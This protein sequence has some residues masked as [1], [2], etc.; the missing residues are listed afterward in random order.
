MKS[1]INPLARCLPFGSASWSNLEVK[2]QKYGTG[3]QSIYLSH[4]ESIGNSFLGS[5]LTSH[6][7]LH[8]RRVVNPR[9]MA[10]V[11]MCSTSRKSK[12]F[13]LVGSHRDFC[14][15]GTRYSTLLSSTTEKISSSGIST[16]KREAKTIFDFLVEKLLIALKEWKQL[17]IMTVAGLLACAF[18]V[19]PSADAVDALKTCACLLKECRVELA[20]CIGNPLCAAN[21][22]CL[23]TCNNRPDETECQIKCGDLLENSVV[24]EFNECAVS[25]KKCVPTK[26]DIGE[27]PVPD[28]AVLVKSFNISD[29]S[30]K[31]FITSGLNPTFDTFNCQQHVFHIESNQLV[32]N[33]SWRIQTP[34]GGFFT[35]SAIQRFVQDPNQPGI[36]YNHD[37]EYLHYQDDWY[38]LSSKIENKQ[39]DYIFVYYRGKNDAWDG[40]GGAVVYT[41]NRV[42]PESIVPELERAAKSVGRDFNKFIRTDNTCGPEPTIVE[43]LEKTVEE[44]EKTILKEVEELEGEV[45]KIG[46]TEKT[47]LERLTEGFKVLQEDEENFLRELSK[48]EMDLLSELK[49]ETNEV[50]KLFGKALPLR[51]LR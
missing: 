2:T 38:I 36:L 14:Y 41:R 4:V 34:D 15:F 8:R 37:N 20:K 50:E 49:M 19:V 27:F 44:G 45:E 11:K 7:G 28:P 5:G 9:G 22:A 12:F 51:K 29:F 24:D 23:Q 43:R 6:A 21:I 3:S 40:Y 32:G 47:L 17:H 35:R 46:K 1:A 42:L 48:E 30:G 18:M 26:S 16:S 10:L 39:D 31:W 33:L 13:Q 25:R